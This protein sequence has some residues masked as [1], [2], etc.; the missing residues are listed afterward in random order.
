MRVGPNRRPNTGYEVEKNEHAAEGRGG[1]VLSRPR[2]GAGGRYLRRDNSRNLAS[3]RAAPRYHANMPANGCASDYTKVW[4]IPLYRT[5]APTRHR[6]FAR[7][8]AAW[9]DSAARS[10]AA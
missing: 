10:I 3:Y 5:A 2:W 6:T 8:G 7:S 4:A 1:G 9:T